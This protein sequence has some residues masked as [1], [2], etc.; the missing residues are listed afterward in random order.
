MTERACQCHH[1]GQDQRAAVSAKHGPFRYAIEYCKYCVP[2]HFVR[3]QCSAP[4]C[5]SIFPFFSKSQTPHPQCI[6]E[7]DAIV[8]DGAEYGQVEVE[9]VQDVQ[10]RCGDI[11]LTEL[12]LLSTGLMSTMVSCESMRMPSETCLVGPYRP[13]EGGK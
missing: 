3:C 7:S 1:R 2:A 12:E 11:F 10:R 6:V 13:H 9:F 4:A 8:R 5:F